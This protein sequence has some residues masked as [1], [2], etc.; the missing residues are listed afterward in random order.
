MSRS[1]SLKPNFFKN[2]HLA[3]LGL[4]SQLLFAGLWTLADRAGRLEDR[5]LRIKAEIFPY[6]KEDVDRL[7]SGL[8][9][10]AEPF[11]CRYEVSGKRYIQI[12]NF[13][14]HQNPHVKEP[15]S[16]IPAPDL[17]GASPVLNVLTPDSLNLTPLTLNP[18]SPALPVP[19]RAFDQIWIKYPNKDGR[20]AAE[21]SFRASVRTHQDW[22]DIQNA[23]PNYLQS[24]KV[25]EGFIKNGSTWFNNWRDWINY[26]GASYGPNGQQGVSEYAAIAEQARTARRA[27]GNGAPTSA[28][29]I[30]TGLRNLPKI[31]PPTRIGAGSGHYGDGRSLENIRDDGALE[32]TEDREREADDQDPDDSRRGP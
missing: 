5:P 4:A 11:I 13:E 20:K 31:P 32:R 3:E 21:K 9:S 10:C 6:Q 25:K 2:E 23:L 27:A 18:I 14:K 28:G 22:L 7:L 29:A 8:A 19:A 12:T 1:R 17:S 24:D 30:L 16:T 26:K 15:E